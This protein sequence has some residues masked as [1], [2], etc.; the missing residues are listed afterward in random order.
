M[1]SVALGTW[2][3]D[4]MARFPAWRDYVAAHIDEASG[5][6]GVVVGND[7]ADGPSVLDGTDQER[8]AIGSAVGRLWPAWCD[9]RE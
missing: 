6:S 2:T 1:A 7:A 9:V 5:L 3:I 8:A 4:D